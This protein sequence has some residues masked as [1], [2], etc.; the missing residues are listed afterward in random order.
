MT[1][2]PSA[3]ILDG[4][5]PPY[6]DCIGCGTATDRKSPTGH[7]VCL[8]CALLADE[9]TASLSGGGTLA[10]LVDAT[11]KPI[12]WAIEGLVPEGLSVLAGSPKLGKSW[13]ALAWTIA[14]AGG[15]K[16]MG[17][18]PTTKGEALYIALE[19]GERRLQARSVLLGATKLPT[20]DLN[21]FHYRLDW[22]PLSRNDEGF[23]ALDKWVAN[24]P[25]TKLIVI[26][27]WQKI[28]GPLPGKDK[29]AEEYALAGRLQ[30]FATIHELAI[31]VVHH[32]RKAPSGD[33]TERISGSQAITGAPDT[34]MALFRERGS[35][36]AVLKI[37]GR[38]V[39]EQELA[40]H[41]DNGK[42]RALGSAE[43][44]RV[45]VEQK[46]V[47]DA[48]DA[49]GGE[50][51]VKDISAAINKSLSATS[52]L[53]SKLERDNRVE[54]VKY[55]VW[56]IRDSSLEGAQS[57][58]TLKPTLNTLSTFSG[59]EDQEVSDEPDIGSDEYPE[60]DPW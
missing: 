60:E 52:H 44:Y 56:R 29:Y 13:L 53:I 6:G 21:R 28:A 50:A 23:D 51:A 33:W 30:R 12:H 16:A 25:N 19:D 58:Q 7:W 45:T 26:D 57:A 3:P 35:M 8:K 40:L 39:D 54:K 47:I 15:I 49:L 32:I 27:T 9:T 14:V 59:G 10:G 2:P 43:D 17:T 18:Y 41:F 37:T 55:G 46:E 5:E 1:L 20:E 48:I 31:V 24:H 11:F 34:L 36:D 38:E 4:N 22:P 42:W